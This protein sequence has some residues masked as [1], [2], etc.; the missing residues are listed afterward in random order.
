MAYSPW[1]AVVLAI[2]GRSSN[3]VNNEIDELVGRADLDG[4]IRLIDTICSLSDW[5]QL[6]NIRNACRVAVH[7]GR[8]LWPAATLAEYRLALHSPANW[9]TVVIVAEASRFT[10]GPLTE[11]IAQNHMWGEL[12]DR[13][14]YGPQSTFVAYE[15]ALRGQVIDEPDSLFPALE[16]PV[17]CGTWE[18][19]YQLAEYNDNEAAFPAPQLPSSSN[20]E[21][22][23]TADGQRLDEPEISQAAIHLVEGWTA[24]SNGK[25]ESVVTRGDPACA[26]GAL[27]L[28]SA[29]LRPLTGASAMA[30][31][32][33][34][35]ASGGAHGRRR[36]AATG[37]LNAWW[38]LAALDHSLGSWPLSN[39]GA[40]EIAEQWNW[41]WWDADEAATGWQLQL[42]AHNETEG[43]TWAINAM[44]AS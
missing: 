21:T 39:L 29:N 38:M 18:P 11:V 20:A 31:M 14:P 1:I 27:R 3:S 4:L 13:L 26:L 16:I 32:A 17:A 22:I 37:R 28:S 42:V 12:V 36:G 6:L 43:L 40:H 41:W 25:C 23:S 34:A 5:Q 19:K 30:W 35:G 44:D 24:Q 8:Q 7:S 15:C 33:W 9:A 10:L 2:R